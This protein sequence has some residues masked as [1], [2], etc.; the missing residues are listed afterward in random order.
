VYGGPRS[1][2]AEAE[3][4]TFGESF[5]GASRARPWA[6]SPDGVSGRWLIRGPG[7]SFCAV[8]AGSSG[9]GMIRLLLLSLASVAAK[10]GYDW[11]GSARSGPAKPGGWAFCVDQQGANGHQSAARRVVS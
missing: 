5:T 7:W 11:I 2:T 6:G 4:A 3:A 10:R 1:V 8:C 9:A